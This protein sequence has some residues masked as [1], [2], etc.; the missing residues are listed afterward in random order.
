M[1][2]ENAFAVQAPIEEV[3]A[4][5]LDVERVAP[6]MP[7]AQVLERVGD[8]AYRVAVKVRVGPISMTYRGE[9]QVVERDDTAHVAAMRVKAKEARGQGTADAT[10]RTALVEQPDGTHATIET[11]VL[12]AGKVAAMG[13]GVVTDV[14][15]RLVETFAGNLA[16]MLEGAA[17]AE[18]PAA[19]VTEP[20]GAARRA[21][22][23]AGAEPAVEE[24]LP[25]G[26]LAAGAIAA[27]LR[28]PVTL[29]AAAG[30]LALIGLGIAFAIRKGR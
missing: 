10:V 21:E 20:G 23:A 15:A 26:K 24:S 13:R 8:D 5:L 6:C 7:G 1:K 28:D 30:A 25:I 22:R 17:A 4:T 29:L 16:A 12:L 19:A 9:L 18:E 14:S 3:W 2:F 27:R 11:D